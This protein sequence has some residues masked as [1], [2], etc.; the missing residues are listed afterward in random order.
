MVFSAFCGI[1]SY[2]VIRWF[3]PNILSFAFYIACIK[4]LNNL[5]TN[6]LTVLDIKTL[7]FYRFKCEYLARVG[8]S[9]TTFAMNICAP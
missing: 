4:D 3:L 8:S 9:E 7:S 6:G 5:H 1:V 2:Y